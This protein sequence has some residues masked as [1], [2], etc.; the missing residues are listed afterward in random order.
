MNKTNN[1]CDKDNQIFRITNLYCTKNDRAKANP[2]E[3][4]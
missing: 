3:S 4:G 1:F 2:K